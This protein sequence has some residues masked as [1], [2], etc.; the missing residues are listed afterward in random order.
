MKRVITYTLIVFLSVGLLFGVYLFGR[1]QHPED[2]SNK[3]VQSTTN[4]FPEST[5]NSK[6]KPELPEELLEFEK[7]VNGWKAK[8]K[9]PTKLNKKFSQWKNSTVNMFGSESE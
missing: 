8:V 4:T 6:L 9:K 1:L 3:F 2:I 7:M 5:Q